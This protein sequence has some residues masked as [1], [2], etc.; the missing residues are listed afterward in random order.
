MEERM[1]P[2]QLRNEIEE[3]WLMSLD[4]LESEIENLGGATK[5]T[6]DFTDDGSDDFGP[7][8]IPGFL[9]AELYRLRSFCVDTLCI[10]LKYCENKNMEGVSLASAVADGLISW[11][12]GFPIPISLLSVYIIKRGILDRWCECVETNS[13]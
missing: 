11:G 4:E 5:F 6:G 13:K 12:T 3:F 1:N 9:N 2:A 7:G 10:R 8:Y